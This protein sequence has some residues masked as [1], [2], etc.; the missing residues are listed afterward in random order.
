[1]T[2]D[3]RVKAVMSHGFTSRQAR[4]LVTVV[5]HSGVCMDRHY[6]AFARIAH[7]QNTTDFFAAL[8]QRKFATACTCAPSGP[9]SSTCIIARSTTPLGS[10]I[11]ASGSRL[12]LEWPSSG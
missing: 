8:V 6:C 12:L 9:A 11:A 1:M 7:G 3:E 5:L 2:F 10:H 4:F